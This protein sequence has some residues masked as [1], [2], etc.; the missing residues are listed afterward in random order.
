AGRRAPPGDRVEGYSADDRE[1]RGRSRRRTIHG[2]LIRAG[3]ALGRSLAALSENA[4]TYDGSV[5]A[6]R[7]RD[8]VQ[9]VPT[10][11]NAL[12]RL[13]ARPLWD[14]NHSAA[15]RRSYSC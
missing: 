1:R 7:G 14:Q 10:S 12:L 8:S 3:P 6:G 9:R 11:N 15:L 4:A 2:N 5:R 13:A